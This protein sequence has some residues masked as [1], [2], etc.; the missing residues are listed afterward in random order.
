ML[1]L[2]ILGEEYYDD[3]KQEFYSEN[4]QIL[5]LEHSLVS[6][7]LWE[8]RYNRPFLEA[9]DK[10]QEETLGYVE[11][12]ILDDIPEN[13]ESLL[14]AFHIEQINKYVESPASATTFVDVKSKTRG[15]KQVITSELVY[16]W[17]IAYQ[18]PFE[19]QYWHLNRLF[20]LI[21]ICNIQNNPDKNKM[22]KAEIAARNRALN[23]ERKA[24]LKTR[25]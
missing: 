25:G 3:E 5:R 20:A 24:K 9:D 17:M 15:P 19:C 10:T 21:R 6:V 14:T 23:E 22:S 1:E 11:C 16:Y 12:M 4:D 8:Q 2:K 7:S 18:I 13:L